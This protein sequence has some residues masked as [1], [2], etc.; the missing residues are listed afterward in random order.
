V[1]RFCILHKELDADDGEMTRTRK[2]RRNIIEQKYADLIAGLY[3]GAD[4]VYTETEVTYEDGRK[5]AIRATVRM[6]DAATVAGQRRA[7]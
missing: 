7:A 2:V 3:D 4:S 5:G 6:M 1:H